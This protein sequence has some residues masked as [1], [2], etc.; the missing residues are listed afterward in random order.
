MFAFS[1]AETVRKVVSILPPCGVGVKYGLP[2]SRK[3]SLMT[4]WQLFKHSNMP[5]VKKNER[6]NILRKFI[7]MATKRNI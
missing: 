4:P 7:E 3:S 2:Q 5:Q 6:K 1:D